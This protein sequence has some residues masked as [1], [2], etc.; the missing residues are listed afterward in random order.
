[1]AHTGV[2]MHTDAK[3][4][5]AHNKIMVIDGYEVL[6]RSLNFTKAPEEHNA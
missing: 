6:T 4:A 5:I 3:H 2:P 1:V